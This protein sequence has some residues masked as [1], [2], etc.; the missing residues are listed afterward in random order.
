MV[1][2]R[3]PTL[4]QIERAI[5]AVPLVHVDGHTKESAA[6][7]GRTAARDDGPNAIVKKHERRCC[8]DFPSFP[9]VTVV[10]IAS[11]YSYP[12]SGGCAE[13]ASPVGWQFLICR[14]SCCTF[15]CNSEAL[16]AQAYAIVGCKGLFGATD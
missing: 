3:L 5:A 10:E 6:F 12:R 11:S 13:A 16:K 4:L 9:P 14:L 7:K 2:A 15:A 8:A 1:V